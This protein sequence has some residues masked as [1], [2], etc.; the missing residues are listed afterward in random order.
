MS[1]TY[2]RIEE[3]LTPQK[4]RNTTRKLTVAVRTHWRTAFKTFNPGLNAILSEKWELERMSP[5]WEIRSDQLTDI[6]YEP[7]ESALGLEANMELS[8]TMKQEIE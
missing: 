3:F 1:Y 8:K 7:E 4:D 5:Q 2:G 6:I